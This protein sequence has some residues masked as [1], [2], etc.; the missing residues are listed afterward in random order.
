MA[1]HLPAAAGDS[2]AP[3]APEVTL[4]WTPAVIPVS[5]PSPRTSEGRGAETGVMQDSLPRH[6]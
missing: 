6:P 3:Q 2:G 5:T 4:H 1:Q